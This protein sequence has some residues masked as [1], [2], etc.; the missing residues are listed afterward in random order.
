MF[1][2]PAPS[3]Y[4]MDVHHALL[5]E[6][7]ESR[8][9]ERIEIEG[10]EGERVLYYADVWIPS[11]RVDIEI[12]GRQHELEPQRSYDLEREELM[13]AN[14]I[15]LMRVSNRKVYDNLQ[16]VVDSIMDLCDQLENPSG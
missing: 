4:A 6:G 10:P 11:L 1:E 9:E 13:E 2:T 15:A 12:D 16:E 5:E 3:K 14:G 7:Y 8:L